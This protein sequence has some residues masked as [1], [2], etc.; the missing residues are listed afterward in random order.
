VEEEVVETIVRLARERGRS[1]SARI[2]GREY[3]NDE[4]SRGRRMAGAREGDRAVAG[5]VYLRPKKNS[6]IYFTYALLP[7]YFQLY[8]VAR[9]F[10]RSLSVESSNGPF[11]SFFLSD[12]FFSSFT[13][14][15][16]FLLPA[17]PTPYPLPPCPSPDTHIL[18]L[19]RARRSSLDPPD[20]TDSVK[21]LAFNHTFD[22]A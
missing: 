4:A 12:H 1:Q 5:V 10:A 17:L 11:S 14:L 16:L 18:A 21:L 22:I 3:D 20:S 15:I 19:S 8:T 6:R 2:H 9:P 13:S 7:P